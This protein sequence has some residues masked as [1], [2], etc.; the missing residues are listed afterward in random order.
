MCRG[1]GNHALAKVVHNEVDQ[2]LHWMISLHPYEDVSLG[3]L[4]RLRTLPA[5]MLASAHT[6]HHANGDHHINI[7][8]KANTV[9]PN[10]A[11]CGSPPPTTAS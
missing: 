5:I 3:Q 10:R 7:Q 9:S 6:Q 8:L 2:T 4:P 11:P 1:N